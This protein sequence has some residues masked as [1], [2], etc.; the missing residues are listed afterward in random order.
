MNIEH[1]FEQARSTAVYPE[2][3][4]FAYPV[5]GLC[6]EIGEFLHTV[7]TMSPINERQGEMGDILWYIVNVAFDA[8]LGVSQLVNPASVFSE[9]DH[10]AYHEGW[11]T[12]LPILAGRIAETAKKAIR[13]NDGIIQE[14]K[15]KIVQDSLIDILLCLSCACLDSGLNFNDVAQSNID[16]LFSRQNRGVLQGDGDNR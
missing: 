14:K 16:K 3:C 2:E 1:Y 15:I 5:L 8:G 6:G 11:Q 12:K 4:R 7:N 9:I 13:D 10:G